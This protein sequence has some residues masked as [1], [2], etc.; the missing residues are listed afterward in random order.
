MQTIIIVFNPGKRTN[1]DLDLRYLIPD[2]V[3]EITEGAVRDNGYDYI[4]CEGAGPLLGIW[5]ETEN[6][7]QS[8][9]V[10][11]KLFREEKFLDNDLSLSAELYISEN[12]TEDLE[13]CTQVFPA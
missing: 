9:P 7:A 2:R 12:E 8:W 10:I 5:L 6:A 1:P 4:D 13:N 3:S 11:D